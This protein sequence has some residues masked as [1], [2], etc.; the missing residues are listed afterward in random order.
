MRNPYHEAMKSFPLGSEPLV[1]FVQQNLT[2]PH[3][4]SSLIKWISREQ[5]GRKMLVWKPEI[6]WKHL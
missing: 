6:N 2:L 4:I 3:T 5:S 1:A